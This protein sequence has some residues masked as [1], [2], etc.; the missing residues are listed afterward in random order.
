MLPEIETKEF[1]ELIEKI[2]GIENLPAFLAG[3]IR[4]NAPPLQSKIIK[5]D[6]ITKEVNNVT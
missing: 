1:K 5:T 4:I 6:A 2:G 3:Y